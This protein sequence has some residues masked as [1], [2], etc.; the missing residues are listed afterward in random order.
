M[1]VIEC[2]RRHLA[3]HYK[4]IVGLI[5]EGNWS[6]AESL[7]HES[8]PSLRW[9]WSYIFDV[10]EAAQAPEVESSPQVGF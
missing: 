10:N 7:S 4:C 3:C 1:L 8:E 9:L 6:G 2:L 5:F